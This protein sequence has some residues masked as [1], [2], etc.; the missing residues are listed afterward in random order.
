MLKSLST[1]TGENKKPGFQPN[2]QRNLIRSSLWK[3]F[4]NYIKRSLTSN[5][6]QTYF[7]L[8]SPFESRTSKQLYFKL[9]YLLSYNHFKLLPC[10]AI[11]WYPPATKDPTPTS[12]QPFAIKQVSELLPC[13]YLTDHLQ[14][15]AWVF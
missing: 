13:T 11:S 9:C 3:E 10:Q 6:R 14:V 1:R 8:P 2:T 7:L 4:L 5:A 15:S 12:T